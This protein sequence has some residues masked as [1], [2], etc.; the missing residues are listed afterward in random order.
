MLP[1]IWTSTDNL[2]SFFAPLPHQQPEKSK[3]WK[4]E[5]NYWKYHHFTLVYLNGNHMMVS[6]IWSATDRIFRWGSHLYVS[7]F[8]SVRPFVCPS[9]SR[10]P[11]LSN[12]TSSNHNFWNT[13][14]K[15]WYHEVFFSFLKIFIFWAVI[16]VKGQKIAQN[17]K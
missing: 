16:G 4:R 10:A 17:E 3:F 13:C 14:V 11:Y 1:E 12:S 6:E 5:K 15:W 2:G 8:P 9:V 7:L